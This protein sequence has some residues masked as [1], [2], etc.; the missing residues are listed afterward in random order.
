MSKY[1]QDA[2]ALLPLLGGR[3]NIVALTHCVT[4][5]RFVLKDES[6][7]DVEGIEGLKSVK[8]TFT[9][10]GQFQIVIGNDVDTFYND[11][12]ELTGIETS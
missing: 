9:Q 3:D 2:K 10:A 12:N 7:T 1:T 4:R 6:I 5:L 8:G 11:F